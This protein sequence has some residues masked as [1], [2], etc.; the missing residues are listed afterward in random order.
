MSEASGAASLRERLFVGFQ[1]LLPQH[2]LSRLI[3]AATRVRTP[4]FKNLLTGGFLKLFSVDM[5]EAV[6]P[7]P[8]AYR[9]STT[10]SRVPC[11]LRPVP[12]RPIMLPS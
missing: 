8:Y 4:W 1:Y 9:T 11:G 2:A 7:D 12:L 3:L 6:Q 5:S 10:S